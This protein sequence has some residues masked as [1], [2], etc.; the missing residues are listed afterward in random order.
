MDR[1][2]YNSQSFITHSVVSSHSPHQVVERGIIVASKRE[3]T[4]EG[5]RKKRIGT[6]NKQWAR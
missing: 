3:D 5:K 6:A 1:I 4:G 2:S